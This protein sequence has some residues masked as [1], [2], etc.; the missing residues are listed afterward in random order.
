MDHVDS[1]LNAQGSVERLKILKN[2]GDERKF[3]PLDL[4]RD[5]LSLGLQPIEHGAILKMTDNT[6]RIAFEDFLTRGMFEWQQ[7]VASAALWEWATRTDCLMWHRTYALALDSQLPQRVAYT[8]LDLAWYGAGRAIIETFTHHPG[9]QDMS[10]TFLALVFQRAMQWNVQS[11][12]LIAFAEDL[13]RQVN[14]GGLTKDRALSHALCYL[15]RFSP[16]KIGNQAWDHHAAGLWPEITAHLSRHSTDFPPSGGKKAFTGRFWEKSWPALWERHGIR[17]KDLAAFLAQAPTIAWDKIP[18][19]PWTLLAGIPEESVIAAANELQSAEAFGWTVYNTGNLLLP[20]SREKLLDDLK[21]RIAAA[22][23]P[24]KVLATLS[25]RDRL[26]LNTDVKNTSV[27]AQILRERHDM[28]AMQ[29]HG[30]APRFVVSTDKSANRDTVSRHR[31]I[32]MAYRGKSFH[33]FRRDNEWDRLGLA[34]NHPSEDKLDELSRDARQSPPIFHVCFLDTLGRFKGIDKA[35]LK[36]LDFI[37]SSEEDIIRAVIRA[38]A[39]IGTARA[40]QELVHFLTRPNTTIHTKVEIAQLLQNADLSNLQAELRS[41]IQDLKTEGDATGAARELKEALTAL[42]AV[43]TSSVNLTPIAPGQQLPN[44]EELEAL[45]ANRIPDYERLSSEAKRALRTAQFFQLQVEGSGHAHTIDLSPAIDMQYKALELFFR[46]TFEEAVSQILRTGV[47]QR[48]LDVIGYARPIP[49]AMDEFEAYIE[50][51]PVINTIPFFSRF[52][53]RKMLRAMCQF[54]AGKRFTL[55]GLKAFA[56]FFICF[57]RKQC[58]Y[59]LENLFPV[60]A[61]SDRQLAEFCKNLHVFQDFRNRAAHEGFHPEAS[62][63]LEGIWKETAMVVESAFN[64]K[65]S[66]DSAV[67]KQWEQPVSQ[68]KPII[69][70]KVS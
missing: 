67:N 24:A 37:R 52:K 16:D 63:D 4:A 30:E 31:F 60:P 34:W 7:N 41:A 27:F 46:E 17:A 5:L 66:Y 21:T 56:L 40:H 50:S 36:I 8:L 61:L 64:V 70:K 45:L 35:A 10:G 3:L 13:I 65:A 33:D 58:R 48:K 62:N 28:L 1:Y 47:I 2:M 69:E 15:V 20:A 59:G 54:R 51:L 43:P 12:R 26:E 49:E 23:D 6:D 32:D 9:L 53:L 18:V 29:K 22:P 14:Q 38:L 57:G 68:S 42:L 44:T 39:G 55:D 11:E 19:K 25:G